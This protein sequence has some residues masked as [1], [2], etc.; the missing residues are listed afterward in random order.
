MGKRRATN[1]AEKENRREIILAEAMRLFS[2]TKYQDIR[3]EDVAAQVGLA[4]GTLYLYFQAKEALFLAVLRRE[5][6]GWFA[7]IDTGLLQLEGEARQGEG[8]RRQ[9]PGR[10]AALI[11]QS[12]V[13]RPAFLRLAAI[14]HSILEQ[15]ADAEAVLSFKRF[16]R[17]E[18]IDTGKLL[19]WLLPDL[20]RESGARVLLILYALM[21][22]IQQLAEPAPAVR[23]GMA[24]PE[25]DLFQ[26]SFEAM[27]R[28]AF[29]TYLEGVLWEAGKNE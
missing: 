18:M 5:F 29:S 13:D 24:Q 4:K 20:P 22:G 2:E 14:L 3:M 25:L 15:S 12:L 11:A 21:V 1:R 8:W 28:Q 10:I 17:D 7:E 26:V 6:A 19:E 27:F 16:L 9:A 23:P